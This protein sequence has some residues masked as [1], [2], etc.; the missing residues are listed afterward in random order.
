MPSRLRM[1]SLKEAI[2]RTG[3]SRSTIYKLQGDGKFPLRVKLTQKRS[4]WPEQEVEAYM[5][6]AMRGRS[7]NGDRGT[8]SN[9]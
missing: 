3:L 4:A 5:E 9:T 1:L 8:P 7:K 6:R 2:T